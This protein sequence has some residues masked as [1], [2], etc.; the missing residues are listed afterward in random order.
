MTCCP[1]RDPDSTRIEPDL[2]PGRARRTSSPIPD[3]FVRLD[4]CVTS[5][6]TDD[7]VLPDDGEAPARKARLRAF[8]IDPFTVTNRWF[9]DFVTATGY[10]TAAQQ[11]GT[12]FVFAQF[13]PRALGPT[14]AVAQAPWWRIIEGAN[15]AHP[16]GPGSTLEG[17]LD[18]PAVHISF[19]D[20]QVFAVWAGGRLPSEAEWEHAARGGAGT[21]RFPWG[22]A[23]PD[24]TS[25]HPCN[26]W[27]GRFPTENT[28]A[29][30]YLGTAPVD[31]FGPN[32]YGLF[33]MAGNVWEWCA[34]PFR[35]RSL[36]QRARERNEQSVQ[37]NERVAKGGSYM[38]HR[39][40]CY[41]YRIAARS[42]LSAT[43]SAGH[44]GFRVVFDT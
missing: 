10:V 13:V 12:S 32:G 44:T 20:A 6:G 19:R 27:Q 21:S 36:M 3:R 40:Y 38:C 1:S 4:A 17:R 28:G 34:D 24:D 23:E 39:N 43:S 2:S 7:P 41:R 5:I 29:D 22:M 14:R 30:G 18:H 33:N 31:A 37:S 42:G 15:W 8:A 16:D 9:T 11:F 26:I 35:V 25:Y